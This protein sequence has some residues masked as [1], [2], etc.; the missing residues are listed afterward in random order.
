MK[1]NVISIFIL[2]LFTPLFLF[3]QKV[4]LQESDIVLISE[5][6]HLQKELGHQVWVNW[7]EQNVPLLYKK[8]KFKYLFFH[9]DLPK[10]YK[11]LKND[12]YK[13][14]IFFKKT[15]DT[16]DYSAMFPVNNIP[17]V[18]VSSP[19]KDDNKSEW[20]LKT[21]HEMFHIFQSNQITD[22]LKRKHD[23]RDG[24]YKNTNELN[25]PYIY[26]NKERL[27][28]EKLEAEKVYDA[29]MKDSLNEN[30][31]NIYRRRFADIYFIQKLL[32]KDSL[33]IKYKSHMEWNEGVARYVEQQLA[34]LA[35]N[36]NIYT[37]TIEYQE[38][39]P[40]DVFTKIS[41]RYQRQSS[42]SPIRFVGEGVVGNVMFYYMGMGKAFLL[43]KIKPD[44]KKY[45][46]TA[47]LDEQI[48][49][50]EQ[51]LSCKNY[52]R[53]N[54]SNKSNQNS[55]EKVPS[56]R[57][58]II[59]TLS[60][61]DSLLRIDNGNFWN[62]QIYGP[63]LFINPT[64]REFIANENNSSNEFVKSTNVY[65]DTLPNN[66]NIANT[67]LNWED[68]RWTMVML[69]LPTDRASRNNLV[70]HEL[71]HRI[72]PEIGFENL[73]EFSNGHLD[74]YEGRLLLK[75]ELQ[76]LTKALCANND[77]LKTLHITNALTFRINRQSNED[78]KKAENSLELNEGLAEYTAIMLSGRNEKEMKSHFIN[79]IV[80]FY[81]NPTFV[82]SF[83]YQT[84][85][86][87]GYLLSLQKNNWHKEI[88][89]ETNLTDLFVNSFAIDTITNKSFKQIAEQNDY[90]YQNIVAKEKVRENE[91]LAKIDS[92]K[93]K[94][95]KEPTLK[96]MFEN[97]NISFDPRNIMPLENIGTVYPNIRVTDNFGILTV[98]DG[99]L[100]SSD[101]SNIIVSEP[102]EIS[103]SIVKGKGWTLELKKDWKVE[104]EKGKYKLKK[105]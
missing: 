61:V 13:Y 8:G 55:M 67:A 86:L 7:V 9:T 87:Y 41:Q 96:L 28:I 49:G 32:I 93:T 97:M 11:K 25:F 92:Y 80:N 98:E 18:V 42:I 102:T 38:F 30:Y 63:I 99:A 44:W 14:T 90:D 66:I 100:L 45:Y 3:A 52:L 60:S 104:K 82:R 79:S 37:P 47:T 88:S 77:S 68:K 27:A 56:E 59:Q 24:L 21:A 34:M 19:K 46:F 76:A 40:N 71:F 23:F 5:A 64:T 10:G 95:L 65:L 105:K 73:Q 101:W 75:L 4:N 36:D 6:F 72:Q 53:Y 39:Y 43:D 69:P 15:K 83:A 33:Q 2:L 16:L 74:T 20:V 81:E 103:E 58:I 85:P 50:K 78:R 62:H 89:Q 57:E 91:R 84:I 1:N 12:K 35:S 22:E 51:F 48:I 17:T 94:F 31:I 26:F 54:N 29:I 70:I